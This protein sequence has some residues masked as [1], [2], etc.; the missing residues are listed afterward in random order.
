MQ[1]GRPERVG[2]ELESEF[3][4]KDMKSP[5]SDLVLVGRGKILLALAI[6]SQI[7]TL[8]ITLP[9]WQVRTSPPNLPWMDV[10]QIPFLWLVLI[11][12]SAV[13][14]W[15]LGRN[16]SWLHLLVLVL[17]CV[18]D[19]FRIQPQF[20]FGWVFIY[21]A[22]SYQI[23]SA[24]EG[25]ARIGWR[26]CRWA[27]IALWFWAGLHKLMSPEWMGYRS[28]E[29]IQ[30]MGMGEWAQK[31]H[32][33]FALV[34]GGSE[35]ALA[36][37][38][39]WRPKVAA[40]LCIPL[41][42]GIVFT[43]LLSNWNFSVL[44]WNFTAAVFGF[45]VLRDS[46]KG[47]VDTREW[48]IVGALLVL[49]A[50]FYV[51]QVDRAF[52]FVLYS[53]MTPSGLISHMD[54][55]AETD[56]F[57]PRIEKIYGWKEL[58]VPFPLE[59]RTLR[60]YFELTAN[61]GSKLY[62]RDPRTLLDD[63]YFLKT[64]NGSKRITKNEF[65]SARLGTVMGIAH[66]SK[67]V[68]FEYTD[69]NV[70]RLKRSKKGMVY[71][72]EFTPDNYSPE[73]LSLIQGYPNLEQINFS[74]CDVADDDLKLLDGLYRLEGVGLDNTRVTEKGLRHLGRLPVIQRIQI[75]G[76]DITQQQL[77]EFWDRLD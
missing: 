9:T 44:P 48:V 11:F 58:A 12:V 15:W 76:S 27:L 21:A 8:I 28:F 42:I 43:L 23:S 18:W 60:Q 77:E 30:G 37:I 49:P 19:Q 66:D 73:L 29:F 68:Y 17:A 4:T 40:W 72:I 50:L 10:P 51:G 41:H 32:W 13:V 31:L 34:V 74:G 14:P 38:A 46:S 33:W 57:D 71:A 2:Q 75:E 36:I 55:P 35:L 70:R 16:G 69:K 62:I 26:F 47:A 7:T 20:Y 22:S 63:Q 5:D 3:V 54:D 53:G 6:L 67:P 56:S 39:C 1:F 59:R 24:S 52:S 61:E 64:K 45:L 25:N 65:F